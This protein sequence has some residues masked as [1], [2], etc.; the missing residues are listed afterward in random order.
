MT[1][2]RKSASCCSL[3][4]MVVTAKSWISTA[5]A[6]SAWPGDVARQEI[7]DSGVA[8]LACV[9]QFAA[10]AR[11]HDPVV[12]REH[13]DSGY[14]HPDRIAVLIGQIDILVELADIDLDHFE[15]PCDQRMT[16][17]VERFI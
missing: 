8:H 4:S 6:A 10:L 3:P 2:P 13:D 16:V 12:G 9:R 17:A 15:V 5:R 11:I 14:A 1:W 7:V